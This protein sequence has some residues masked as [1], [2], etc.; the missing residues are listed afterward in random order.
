V[1][2]PVF[3]HRDAALVVVAK[4][5]GV[6]VVPGRGEPPSASLR[7]AVE[8]ALG[9]PV[10][11]VHRL[12][13]DTTGAVIFALDADAHRALNAAFEERRV[14][15]T[16][17]A[18]TWGVPSPEEG[19]LIAPLHAARKGRMRPAE[20][21][22]PGAVEAVT[23]WRTLDVAAPSD[24]FPAGAAF[25]RL[26]PETGR[27]HQLRV[28]LRALGAPILGDRAYAPERA[29]AAAP[30]LMLHASEIAAPHPATGAALRVVAPAPEDFISLR[31]SLFP[32]A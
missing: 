2:P 21:G 14:E 17:L 16:Y 30:R 22:E 28:H 31:T 3:L 11:P 12:D 8:A 19:R 24:A 26:R 32:P 13:R 23:G 7:A 15:K 4:P 20:P 5:P 10:L 18:L 9:R 27:Q 6:C 1:N 25:V 29:R